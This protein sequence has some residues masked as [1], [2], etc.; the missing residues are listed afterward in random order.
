M[1]VVGI[2]GG[3]GSGKSTVARGFRE[4]GIEV[5]DADIAAR[6]V[7]GRDS[8]ALKKI[9]EHFGASALL[10]DGTLDRPKMRKLVF[11]NPE[12]KQWLEQL[13]HPLI[14]D[15]LEQQLE[16]ANSAYAM[17]ESPLLLETDQHQMVNHILLVDI[18]EASQIQRAIA[19]DGSS[20]EQIQAI[21]DSQMS[22]QERLTKAD[23]ILD[24]SG[25]TKDALLK[26][27]QLHAKYLIMASEQANGC[28]Q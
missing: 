2:T 10:P 19:R 28:D 24:N 21:M 7:V 14:R 12:Q 20:K 18:P 1:F 16:Q 9:A 4:S 22:R 3:I 13:L 26:I 5:I 8:P 6:N 17:L 25:T 15:W 27:R 23:D 11:N